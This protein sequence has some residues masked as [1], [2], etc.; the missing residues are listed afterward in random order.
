MIEEFARRCNA[1]GIDHEEADLR[2]ALDLFAMSRPGALQSALREAHA[3]YVTVVDAEPLPPLVVDA[4]APL[5]KARLGAYEVFPPTMNGG[6]QSFAEWLDSDQSGRIRWW[7]RL[8]ENTKWAVTLILPTG[9]RFFPDF[10]VGVDG[11]NTPNRIALVEIKDDGSS[12]RLHSDDNHMKIRVAHREYKDVA[13]TV[14]E[15][16]AWANA[17]LDRDLNRIFTQG[18]FDVEALAYAR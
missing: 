10:A 7:L 2:R 16:D 17:R 5:Q 4:D 12:G 6:E 8:Q 1:R 9:R 11:R 18:R 13:W 3:A 14:R 15:G